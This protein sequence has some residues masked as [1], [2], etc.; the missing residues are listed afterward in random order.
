M[1][2][3]RLIFEVYPVR[4]V[5]HRKSVCLVRAL[6]GYIQNSAAL[7]AVRHVAQAC[8]GSIVDALFLC[9]VPHEALCSGCTALVWC[10]SVPVWPVRRMSQEMAL[11]RVR[12]VF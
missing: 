8:C 7:Y 3:R 11:S 2:I 1:R 10:A 6:R 4:L 5:L 12:R 9:A